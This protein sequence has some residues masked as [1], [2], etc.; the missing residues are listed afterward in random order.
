MTLR[1]A[2]G[3]ALG[4]NPI[5]TIPCTRVVRARVARRLVLEVH[6]AEA[7]RALRTCEASLIGSRRPPSSRCRRTRCPAAPRALA[8]RWPCAND[9]TAI[10]GAVL[11]D[12]ERN[13]RAWFGRLANEVDGGVAP[14]HPGNATI[15]EIPHR[16][17]RALAEGVRESL[18]AHWARG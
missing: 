10:S 13:H 8:E 3:C 1:N 5:G 6:L 14:P 2:A 17:E 4:M 7:G 11:E 9:R 12:A 18:G 15:V 16:R